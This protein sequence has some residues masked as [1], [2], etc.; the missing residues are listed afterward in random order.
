[1]AGEKIYIG[2]KIRELRQARGLTQAQFAHALGVS[3][4]YVNL[5][6]RNQRS[7]SVKFLVALSDTFGINWRQ[8]TQGDQS[9]AIADLRQITRDPAFGE[10]HPDIEELRSAIDNSPN[11]VRGL[12]SLFRTYRDY[13]E[14]LS[15]Q[16]EANAP[17]E[18]GSL[19]SEEVVLRFFRARNNYFENVE[20]CAAQTLP[21]ADIDRDEL[22]G[23]LKVHLR[24]KLGVS[25][26]TVPPGEIGSGLR[27]FDRDKN[28]IFLSEGLDYTNKVFQLAHTIAL[29]EHSDA[30][31]A[32]IEDANI[33]DK[34]AVARCRV[35]LANYFAAALMMPYDDFYG[36]ALSSKYDID[37]LATRFQVSY[38]HV[39]HRLTTL[40]KPGAR[41]IPF[42]MLRVDRAGNVTKRFNATPI[43]LARYGGT[44]PRLDVHYCFRVAGRIMTQMIEMPDNARYLTINRTVDR[45]SLRFTREDNRLALCLGCAIEHAGETIYG[46]NLDIHAETEATEVGINC[47]LCPRRGCVQ[48]ANEPFF[49][50]LLV[51][52][53]RRGM[54]RFES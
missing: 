11:L 20:A 8:L 26:S 31:N 7:A 17:T 49:E 23:I 42:F 13:G 18:G 44:C 46:A 38:E 35:E 15:S 3:A 50:N 4:S 54:T 51:D 43:Q 12:F 27:Y 9:L 29:I 47:R 40:Q 39:C 45:P 28:T 1:M 30:L 34:R 41:A 5:I 24:A 16:L 25:A 37:Y 48:R 53:N 10:H 19:A 14:R 32:E 36:E 2:P 21:Y 22:Y 6:E 52:E 33:S